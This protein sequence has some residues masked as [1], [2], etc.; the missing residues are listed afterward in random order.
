MID[1]YRSRCSI[2]KN[3]MGNYI[4]KFFCSSFADIVGNSQNGTSD[5]GSTL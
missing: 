1:E 5:K 4:F 2:S 3:K